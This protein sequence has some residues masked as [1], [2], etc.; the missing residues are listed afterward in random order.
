VSLGATQVH[1]TIYSAHSI[2]F[3]DAYSNRIYKTVLM[4]VDGDLF[5]LSSESPPISKRK[6]KYQRRLRELLEVDIS[7]VDVHPTRG[8]G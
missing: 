8:T 7:F 3:Q 5:R 2:A 6:R 4:K 1:S